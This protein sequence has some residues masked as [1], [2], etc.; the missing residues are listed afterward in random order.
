MEQLRKF[1]DSPSD[2]TVTASVKVLQLSAQMARCPTTILPSANAGTGQQI[3]LG[4]TGTLDNHK[5]CK[6]I[7]QVSGK[8]S[9]FIDSVNDVN[10]SLIAGNSVK[11]DRWRDHFKHL[12]N[13][14]ERG[15]T[16]SRSSAPEFTPS[17]AYA[18]SC[19]PPSEGKVA[20]AIQKLHNNMACV[21]ALVPFW[22]SSTLGNY[23]ATE[24][25]IYWTEA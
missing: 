16:P 13:F 4:M 5:L 10:C 22:L 12:L 3:Q 7:R 18:V 20:D 6:I 8:P 2:T 21:S 14:Y 19:D 1:A 15:I 11:V 23:L 9:T 25:D 17:S 24:E